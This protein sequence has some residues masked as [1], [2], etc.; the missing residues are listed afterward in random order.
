MGDKVK[1]RGYG[2]VS[3]LSGKLT[4]SQEP[5]RLL[6]ANG[7]LGIENGTF[8]ALGQQLTIERGKVYYAGGSIKKPGF[9]VRATRVI[10]NSEVGVNVSGSMDNPEFDFFS[11]DP[12]ISESTARS[13]LLTGAD[14]SQGEAAKLYLGRD[15]ND[16]VS[17]GA[18]VSVDGKQTEFISRYRIN[19]RLNVET[20][21][22]TE[23]SG[24]GLTYTIE[25]E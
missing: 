18:E 10:N 22:S 13:M 21:S 1:F 17:V 23:K 6:V 25:L 4:L 14:Q 15:L 9:V 16:R 20:N 2:L 5:G 7:D 24:L 12:A 8:R 11:S 3:D 19:S